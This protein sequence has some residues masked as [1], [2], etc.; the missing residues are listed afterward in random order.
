[1]LETHDILQY[2]VFFTII[3]YNSETY[4]KQEYSCAS[5]HKKF[6]IYSI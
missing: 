1:M 2:G 5:M 3:L 4:E 6:K